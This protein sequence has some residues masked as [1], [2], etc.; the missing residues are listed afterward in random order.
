[1]SVGGAAGPE[2]QAT[3]PVDRGVVLVVRGMTMSMFHLSP[4]R[5]NFRG[6]DVSSVLARRDNARYHHAKLVSSWLERPGCRI[7]LHFIPA[8]CPHLTPI[9]RLWGVM[10]KNITHNK[11]YATCAQFADATLEFLRESGLF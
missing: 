4:S 8:Y 9:E 1:M 5:V 6:V 10:H 11:T 7:K 2:V 3:L